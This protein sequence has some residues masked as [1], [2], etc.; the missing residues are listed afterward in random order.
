MRV[1]RVTLKAMVASSSKAIAAAASKRSDATTGVPF[2]TKSTR[3]ME[4]S[5]TDSA[6]YGNESRTAVAMSPNF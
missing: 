4:R 6:L 1:R 2:R 3:S 5:L